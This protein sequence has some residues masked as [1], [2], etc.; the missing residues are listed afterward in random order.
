MYI[1]KF[2]MRIGQFSAILN[3]VCMYVCVCVGWVIQ[4][5]HGI[6]AEFSSIGHL[7]LQ[8]LQCVLCT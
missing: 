1:L 4:L 2:F 3:F 8:R 6:E 7:T 5:N